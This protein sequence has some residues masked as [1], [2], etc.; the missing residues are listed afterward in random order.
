MPARGPELPSKRVETDLRRRATAGE[1][2][3]DE[4]LPSVASLAAHYGVARS[5][6]VSALRRM[7]ADGLVEIV[8][9]WG[10]F[11]RLGFRQALDAESSAL[12]TLAWM[13]AALRELERPDLGRSGGGCGVVSCVWCVVPGGLYDGVMAGVVPGSS[14][15]CESG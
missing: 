9:N 11:R 10:T 5:T 13:D 15:L 14:W 6:V 4:K 7:E 2:Q 12:A 3:R 8:A 1:W